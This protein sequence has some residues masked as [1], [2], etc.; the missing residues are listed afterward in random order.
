MPWMQ[1]CGK[2][3]K[4][5]FRS[6]LLAGILGF[7]LGLH[8][9]SAGYLLHLGRGQLKIVCGSKSIER[10]LGDEAVPESVKDKIRLVLDAKAFGEKELGLA[11]SKNY[12]RYYVVETAPIAF[13]LTASP[14]LA[15][16]AY[17]WCFP[18][19][20][21]LPYKGFFSRERALRES[22]RMAERGYDVYLRHV[23]AYS[24]LGWFTDPIFSTMMDYGDTG[25]VEMI[26]HEMVH[27][28]VFVKH[29]GAFNEGVATFVGEKGTEIFFRAR[30]GVGVG[31]IEE[32][33]ER[34]EAQRLFRETMF[35]IAER[36]RGLYG[37]DLEDGDKLSRRG[38]ILEEGKESFRRQLESI[39]STRYGGILRADWNNAFV[40]SY[41]TYHENPDLWEFL[42][43]R[44]DRN[45][46]A[47]VA[48]LKTLERA[49]DPLACIERLLAQGDASAD[50]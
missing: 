17:S 46:R 4:A 1:P 42:Y 48:W 6:F 10:V 16:E 2:C 9:C 29:Q 32:M 20:G 44:F 40:V 31:H 47:M 13:N 23:G 43:D 26:L 33:Q 27:G 14:Q 39:D 21:C 49:E 38:R 5:L 30:G 15:L 34:K 11:S 3:G 12:T 8:G 45:L 19:A 25:L 24:T 36:L 35:Q 41:L 28:T 22:N 18:V 37:M 7:S 50:H